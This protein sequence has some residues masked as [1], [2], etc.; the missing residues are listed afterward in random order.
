MNIR[1][2]DLSKEIRIE[3][4]LDAQLILAVDPAK[5]DS[6]HEENIQN[7]IRLT[8][9]I[10]VPFFVAGRVERLEDVKKYLY[11]GARK[12]LLRPDQMN[13]WQEACDRFGEDHLLD[14]MPENL[15]DPVPAFAWE[16]L[17]KGPDG[18][19]PVIV[20]EAGTGE[21]LMLAYMNQEAYEATVRTGRMTYY[22]RSRQELWIKGLTSG[23]YQY[24]RSL[25]IDCDNDTILAKVVQLGAACHTGHHSCFFRPILPEQYP[26]TNPEKVLEDVYDVILDRR[27]H[28]KKGSYTNYLFDKGIDKI[29]K[30]VGEEAAEIII[31]A[32]NPNPEEVIYEISD[33][34]YHVMV[35]MA[36][37]DVTWEEI[38]RE[39]A[40]R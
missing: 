32:K 2:M 5:N 14:Q 6:E 10:P 16:E 38:T 17:K 23:H 3:E 30:K 21:V 4:Y 1:H 20:Q 18:L 36:V 15:P 29:L 34:L 40:R 11:A 35:L 25:M 37:K 7:L 24:V 28:P 9:E 33:F 27:K 19:I 39:L 31:A 8:R 12:V 13:V 22:S 26:E